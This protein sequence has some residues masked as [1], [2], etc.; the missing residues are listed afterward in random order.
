MFQGEKLFYNRINFNNRAERAVEVPVAFHFLAQRAGSG[1]I[2]E[3]GNVLQHYENGLSDLL[4]IRARRIVD[5]FEAGEGIDCIDIMDV[6]PAEKYQTIVSISTL[7]H[8]GQGRAPTGTFGE[9][10]R[11]TDLEA[12]IKAVAKVYDLLAPGGQALITVPFGKL[13]DGGWYVQFSLDYLNLLSI[14]YGL[15]TEAI[16][17]RCLKNVA[18]EPGWNNPCQQWVEVEPQ[19][20]ESVRYDTLRGGARAVAVITLTK[21]VQPFVLDLSHPPTP[22]MY[23]GSHIV[24]TLL[25]TAGLLKAG[26]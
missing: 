9:Q 25:F 15:P 12:P 10:K 26:F 19:A 22:L 7:E 5:K 21:G 23:E 3:V 4:C 24:K 8:V 2:L 11:A 17:I 13:I 20:L 1:N 18:R 14:K 16:A 6:D